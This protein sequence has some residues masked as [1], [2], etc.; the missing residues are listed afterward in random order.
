MLKGGVLLAAYAARR[1]T[2]DIDVAAIAQANEPGE[3]R[4]MVVEIASIDVDDGL[5]F[6][7]ASATAEVIRDQ[8]Q[9][10]GGSGISAVRSAGGGEGPRACPGG[11]RW[12]V[13][14]CRP[15]VVPPDP[16]AWTCR[17]SRWCHCHKSGRLPERWMG[18]SSRLLQQVARLAHRR[19]R[20]PWARRSG[21]QHRQ[22]CPKLGHERRWTLRRMS[23]DPG[24]TGG[25]EGTRTPDPHT[26]R[27]ELAR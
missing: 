20:T 3:V 17:C 1:P 9:Y 13:R 22:L 23:K 11:C 24:R 27:S 4:E 12:S 18:R 2:R 6:D 19:P 14:C 16:P 15:L 21:D 8:D 26:A 25:A 10:Q 7:V 5:V